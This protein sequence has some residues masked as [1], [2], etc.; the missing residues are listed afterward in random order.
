MNPSARKTII[1][2]AL[3]ASIAGAYWKVSVDARQLTEP[4]VLSDIEVRNP[5]V[6]D[7]IPAP[8]PMATLKEI[9]QR[10]FS[11]NLKADQQNTL[12]THQKGV[13]YLEKDKAA[14]IRY[15]NNNGAL[16][17]SHSPEEIWEIIERIENEKHVFAFE[18][19]SLKLRWLE[20]NADSEQEFKTKSAQLTAFYQQKAQA[21]NDTQKPYQTPD[22][23]E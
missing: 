2:S 10:P 9:E 1:A 8:S 20:I 13:A 11:S 4:K 12:L 16:K 23:G 22:L 7:D 15:F 14:L 3:C 21:A 17:P 19:L 6:K 18:A 5:I